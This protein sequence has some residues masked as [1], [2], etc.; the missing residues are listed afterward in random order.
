MWEW[1]TLGHGFL[2]HDYFG[3]VQLLSS[4]KPARTMGGL[5]CKVSLLQECDHESPQPSE[6]GREPPWTGKELTI[7]LRSSILCRNPTT[8]PRASP[9]EATKRPSKRTGVL[10]IPETTLDG[11]IALLAWSR[12][13]ACDEV[14]IVPRSN[15]MGFPEQV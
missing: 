7:C 11:P 1:G 12:Q 9:W 15:N 2:T 5:W 4:N 13:D 6:H 8:Q 10:L 14:C 3:G